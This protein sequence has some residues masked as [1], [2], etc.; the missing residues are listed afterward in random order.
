MISGSVTIVTV[1]RICG[2]STATEFSPS[3]ILTGSMEAGSVDSYDVRVDR[4]R[5]STATGIET[6]RVSGPT[7][8]W[9]VSG[10]V[11]TP[12]WPPSWGKI[13]RVDA[14]QKKI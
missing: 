14:R 9:V 6:T 10:V 5:A 11:V 4:G 2:Q 1:R 13:C 8:R 7:T 3:A 12:F